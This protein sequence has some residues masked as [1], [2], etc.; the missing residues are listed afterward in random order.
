MEDKKFLVTHNKETGAIKI[1]IAQTPE[2][3]EQLAINN[4]LETHEFISPMETRNFRERIVRSR[5][6][7]GLLTINSHG[8][9]QNSDPKI[10]WYLQENDPIL[11]LY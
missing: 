3:F 10:I 6:A 1:K 2:D 9:L 11:K 7:A 4:Y 8:E 5:I